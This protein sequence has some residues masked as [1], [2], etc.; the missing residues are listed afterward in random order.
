MCTLEL[1]SVLAG[2]RFNDHPACVSPVIASIL[3]SYNDAL[4]DD[5]RQSLLPC[6]ASI[7]GTRAASSIEAQRT[8]RVMEWTAA[9]RG[10]RH[11][12]SLLPARLQRLGTLPTA[13]SIG[14]QVLRAIHHHDEH[15]HA[16]VLGLVDELIAMQPRPPAVPSPPSR[17]SEGAGTAPAE[18]IAE[19]VPAA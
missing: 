8:A 13:A 4:D 11:R 12:W 9:Q 17:A 6:A 10:R 1:A 16:L 2:E 5:S 14:E 15:T 19:P 18:A 3:R 7:V